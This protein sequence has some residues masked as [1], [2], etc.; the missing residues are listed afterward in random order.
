MLGDTQWLWLVALVGGPLI[1]GV[2]LARSMRQTDERRRN[3][4]AGVA[5]TER[6][7]HRLYD[8]EE[9]RGENKQEN[10]DETRRREE[11]AR[12]AAGRAR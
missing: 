5:M 9:H 1:L 3:D 11:A 2:L 7:T 6:A 10:L 8:E 12:R 4:P